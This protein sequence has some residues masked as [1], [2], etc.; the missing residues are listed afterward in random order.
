MAVRYMGDRV[1]STQMSAAEKS[2]LRAI[3][4]AGSVTGDGWDATCTT[5]NGNV[6]NISVTPPNARPPFL[7]VLRRLAALTPPPAPTCLLVDG[8]RIID[9]GD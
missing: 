8:V 5:V 3:R 7:E 4:T 1:E 6:W 2:A 9:L